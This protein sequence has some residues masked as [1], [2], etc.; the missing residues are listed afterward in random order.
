MNKDMIK[1]RDEAMIQ[2]LCRL[3]E[4]ESVADR[5][6]AGY[7]YGKAVAGALDYVLGLCESFGFRTKNADGRYGFA[8][9]G[10][11]DELIGILCHLDVVPAGKGWDYP[12]FAGTLTAESDGSR[13]LYGRGTLDDKGPAIAAIYAMK[14]LLDSG[15]TLNRRI[16]IIFGQTEENGE[17]DD[18]AEY[19]ACE[20]L[21]DYGFTPDGD[22]PAIYAEKGL[23][24][25]KLTVPL[26]GSG[27]ISVHGG[28]APNM[29][30]DQCIAVTEA[31]TFETTGKST[32]GS[33]PWGGENAITKMMKHLI[34][35][36][37]ETAGTTGSVPFARIYMETIGD[38][39][40]GERAGCA[41]EDEKSGKLTLNAG[42]I[43][44][45]EAESSEGAEIGG[46]GDSCDSGSSGD[47]GA[48]LCLYLDIR[49]P[50]TF[51]G[52]QVAAAVRERMKSYGVASE[53][54]H[55]MAPVYMDKKGPVMTKL[56]TA[57]QE[58]T[59]DDT[60]PLL[61][62]GGTYARSMPN[63]IAFGPNFLGHPC[64][65]H[66]ENEYILVEDFLMLRKI[67]RRAL[68]LL[69]E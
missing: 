43:R 40:Y 24:V 13:R 29:V 37:D 41:F 39:I 18:I 35:S 12:P 20:E 8:E 15:M 66:Q 59:G 67:Y 1:G 32:H 34:A 4:F 58:F 25:L 61:I 53:M 64:P 6:E 68:E 45:E 14:D 48:Q 60:E 63:I 10:E 5:S 51:D 33:A 16:R 31:G 42:M 62:G 11:G 50:V 56:L 23:M 49:Y 9:I 52:E 2:D 54:I 46:T 7:L 47:S 26:E 19:A 69:V 28:S 30:P 44:V 3:L 22:F 57:Y 17:W 27:F 21:P 36:E 65:E 55:H 38:G